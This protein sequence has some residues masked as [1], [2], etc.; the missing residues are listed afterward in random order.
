MKIKLSSDTIKQ[1]LEKTS[2]DLINCGPRTEAW[3]QGEI[4]QKVRDALPSIYDLPDDKRIELDVKGDILQ[5]ILDELDW[6]A[7]MYRDMR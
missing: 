5:Y 6:C 3:E 7:Y 1:V 2:D 4:A